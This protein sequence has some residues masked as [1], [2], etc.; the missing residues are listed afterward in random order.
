MNL[1]PL[2]D[3]FPLIGT[4]LTILSGYIFISVQASK[5]RRA[6]WID[7]FR[8]ELSNFYAIA[9]S[10]NESSTNDKAYAMLNSTSILKLYFIGTKEQIQEQLEDKLNEFQAMMVTQDEEAGEN[11]V[12]LFEEKLSEIMNLAKQIISIEQKKI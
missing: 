6:K 1:P 8:K 2:K 9:L 10:L 4:G 12:E 7:D 11:D 3:F 5:N